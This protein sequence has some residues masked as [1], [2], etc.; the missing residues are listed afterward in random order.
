[1]SAGFGAGGVFPGV[2]GRV[3]G[4]RV[5]PQFGRPWGPGGRVP[6]IRNSFRQKNE[7]PSG[8]ILEALPDKK[9]PNPPRSNIQGPRQPRNHISPLQKPKSS[10]TENSKSPPQKNRH[11]PYQKSAPPQANNSK[12]PP[13]QN[14][15]PR[16]AKNPLKPPGRVVCPLGGS[17]VLKRVAAFLGGPITP[18]PIGRP[19]I[20]GRPIG[21]AFAHRRSKG[22]PMG[23]GRNQGA[24]KGRCAKTGSG[25]GIWVFRPVMAKAPHL[26]HGAL[27]HG[28]VTTVPGAC[29][30]GVCERSGWGRWR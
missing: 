12:S 27:P 28:G 24:A 25:A 21:R 6:S 11:P 3:R 13:A 9:N 26:G 17:W 19:F 20:F 16:P 18:P 7:I 5:S 4:G 14:S 10:P 8:K 2:E 29:Q 15:K 30:V 23:V 1:M 22:Q